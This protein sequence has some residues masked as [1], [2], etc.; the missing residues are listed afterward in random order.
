MSSSSIAGSQLLP[1]QASSL[2]QVAE[3]KQGKL[4]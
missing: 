3:T 1:K 4:H 2:E